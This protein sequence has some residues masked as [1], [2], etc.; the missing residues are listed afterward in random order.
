MVSA[1]AKIEQARAMV[2]QSRANRKQV[3]ISAAQSSS[4]TAAV[5][6]ARANLEAA[7]LQLSYT[8]IIAPVDGVVT[9]KTVRA[10]RR[11]CSPARPS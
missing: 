6:Q 5:A 8:T 7:E 9:Q 10:R 2:M 1:Q 11:S 3:A 4:A